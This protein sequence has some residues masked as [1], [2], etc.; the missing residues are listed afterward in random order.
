[1]LPVVAQKLGNDFE[2][3]VTSCASQIGSGALPMEK[4]PSAGLAIRLR[5]AKRGGRALTALSNALRALPVPVVGH[6]DDHAL[7]LD[8]RCLEDEKGFI[9]NLA[10]LDLSEKPDALA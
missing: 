6:M 9:A 7:V 1:M 5:G 4:L 8:L 3:A 10:A 2:I